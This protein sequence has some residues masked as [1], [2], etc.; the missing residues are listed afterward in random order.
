MVWAYPQGP[1]SSGK[2]A[3]NAGQVLMGGNHCLQL[4]RHPADLVL[5]QLKKLLQ[6]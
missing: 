4:Y 1:E 5:G 6:E 2:N 3:D